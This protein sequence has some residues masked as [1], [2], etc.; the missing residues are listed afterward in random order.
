MASYGV[1]VALS[2]YRPSV[3]ST[4]T[5]PVKAQQPFQ[6]IMH[7]MRFVDEIAVTARGGRGG[8]GCISF[9]RRKFRPRGGPSG[10]NG[11]RGGAVVLRANHNLN[12]LFDFVYSR[13]VVAGDGKRG[14][15]DKCHGRNAADV[16]CDVPLGTQVLDRD[17]GVV[18]D[19]ETDGELCL[20]AKGG[21]G[22]KGNAHFRTNF[23]KAPTYSTNGELGEERDVLLRYRSRADVGLIGKPNAGKSSLLNLCSNCKSA[24]ADYWFTT[25]YPQIG[26]A[27]V[28]WFDFRIVDIPGLV[29]GASHDR[30]LGLS[31]LRHVERCKILVYVLDCANDAA[32]AY[33]LLRQ[34][35]FNYDSKLL[36]KSWFVVLNKI[37]LLSDAELAT[38]SRQL[39][40]VLPPNVS[41]C[42]L[43][44][45][46]G[47]G[48]ADFLSLCLGHLTSH[49]C[50]AL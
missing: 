5:S 14:S 49:A 45:R 48:R 4:D 36:D 50:D 46:N 39:D 29:E 6:C 12:T 41:R 24:V 33:S 19:F 30:G 18:M 31:F 8:D 47:T 23:N 7:D 43:S 15:G 3:I 44:A 17:M 13:I 20:V 22:G 27:A 10:G 26:A 28:D 37:D 9:Q 2:T 25:L 1:Y 16:V 38:V 11:G 34:E 21:L 40:V 35:L 32:S 42:Y